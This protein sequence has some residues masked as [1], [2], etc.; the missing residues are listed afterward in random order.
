MRQCADHSARTHLSRSQKLCTRRSSCTLR[1]LSGLH[2]QS[3]PCLSS[4]GNDP[5]WNIMDYSDDACMFSFS[6]E[7]A[8]TMH[9]QLELHKKSLYV[10]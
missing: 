8:V 7:Q 2:A 4:K 3:G 6:T 9:N 1:A 5:I 10:T